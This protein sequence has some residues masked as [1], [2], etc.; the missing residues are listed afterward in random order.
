M[1][2]AAR[3]C[4]NVLV[5]HVR[6]LQREHHPVR[7]C[8]VLLTDGPSCPI[9][10]KPKAGE[11]PG[12]PHA[13]VPV[14]GEPR[15]VKVSQVGKGKF[16][17]KPS[18]LTEV[19]VEGI[20]LKD[21]GG[22]WAVLQSIYS[23]KYCVW[24][25]QYEE[26]VQT[27]GKAENRG[28]VTQEI[29]TGQTQAKG[30]YG[31]S[32]KSVNVLTRTFD[33]HVDGFFT[34]LK[35][36]NYKAKMPCRTKGYYP[37]Y[38]NKDEIRWQSEKLCLGS[39]THGVKL[40]LTELPRGQEFNAAKITKSRSGRYYLH[41]TTEIEIAPNPELTEVGAVDLGQ[42]RAMV[43]AAPGGKTA[44]ISGK[45]I[46]ALKRQ[47]DQRF[48]GL[49]RKRSATYRGQLRQYLSPE[50]QEKA[51]HDTRYGWRM[52]A[53]RRREGR[54]GKGRSLVD[55]K[56]QN[57]LADGTPKPLRKRSKRQFKILRAQNKVADQTRVALGYANHCVTRLAVDWA[58]ENKIGTLYVGDLDTLPKGRA[59]GK[60]RLNQ[61]KRNSLWEWPT[62]TQ[63]LDQKL[64]EAGGEG[65]KKASER[66]TSQICPQCGRRHKPRDRVYYC[67]PRKGGCG[68]RGDRD[69]VGAVNF[70]NHCLELETGARG[71]LMPAHN[72][73][74][75]IAPAIRKTHAAAPAGVCV[76][77]PL[78]RPG[79]GDSTCEPVEDAA[80]GHAEASAAVRGSGD[81]PELLDPRT[82]RKPRK[83]GKM[84]A[85]EERE[86]RASRESPSTSGSGN[87]CSR[88]TTQK[89]GANPDTLRRSAQTNS[90]TQLEI[91]L[92]PSAP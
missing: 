53:Q 27:R 86:I 66:L 72:E 6:Y 36:G 87:T 54:D 33:G 62:Q 22:A 39:K 64:K 41:L 47:R 75:R 14:P 83:Q 11:H 15:R 12:N 23:G 20:S 40:H 74:L 85:R 18:F 32:A 25:Q 3:D 38:F 8:L 63:Y 17:M 91:P 19:L 82:A 89:T 28:R 69:Q 49:G 78:G 77:M 4:Y 59:K 70:L 51:S 9:N 60:R 46:C 80:K 37:I 71:T 76:G 44:S 68:W 65:V 13:V 35:N 31:L 42:I 10:E 56:Q 50:E 29:V 55:L 90:E 5:K 61:V 81:V 84:Q 92:W 52:I 24:P 34:H 79:R 7:A 88:S 43:I 16:V 58:V 30:D 45:N 73:N 1:F 57:T 2:R 67:S 21:E 48:R 26:K